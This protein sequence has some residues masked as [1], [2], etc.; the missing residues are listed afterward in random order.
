MNLAEYREAFERAHAVHQMAID[1]AHR[2]FVD[3][4]RQIHAEFSGDARVT[5]PK[6]TQ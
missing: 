5:E 1:E 4:V 6:E 3:R 2:E